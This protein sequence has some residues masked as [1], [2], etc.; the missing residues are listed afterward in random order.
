[1]IDHDFPFL[2]FERGQRMS[3]E[4]IA[5]GPPAFVA[6]QIMIMN[7]LLAPLWIGGLAWLLVGRPARAHRF[8]GW[9][10]LGV[11]L[12][13]LVLRAKNYYVAP[14]YP[15]L[16]AA[17]AVALERATEFRARWFR[18]AYAGAVLAAGLFLAP[19]VLPVLPVEGF[20]AYQ[21]AFG[22]FT[23]VRLERTGPSLLP[24]QFA[25]EFGWDE[26][27]RKTALVFNGL[28]EAERNDAAIFANNF[29]EAA[30]I[31]FFGPR[32]GLPRAIGKD[33]NYWLWGPRGYTG[34]AVIVLGSDGTGDREHFRSVEAAAHVG[35]AYSRANEHFD[36]YFCRGLTTDL[37]ALWPRMKGW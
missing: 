28:S 31:D 37:N 21:R 29:G 22:G 6:D 26:M 24:Q 18:G 7:P 13:L 25:D 9:A 30:A 14:A 2:A 36:I 8:L 11:F 12:P 4:R 32:Y 19:F 10:F 16:F 3:M 15:V 17:G 1:L 33:V 23:P 5:R 20:L 27:A 34:R 35:D